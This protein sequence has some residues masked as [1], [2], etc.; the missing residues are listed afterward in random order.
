ML[1]S[2]LSSNKNEGNSN[3][4]NTENLL[5]SENTAWS[6]E[7]KSLSKTLLQRDKT[8]ILLLEEKIKNRDRILQLKKETIVNDAKINIMEKRK[9]QEAINRDLIQF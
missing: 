2:D 6:N 1:Q 3:G 7:N 4:E 9:Q 5:W 8:I